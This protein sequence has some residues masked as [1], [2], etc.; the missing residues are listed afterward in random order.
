M[1]IIDECSDN[2]MLV[3]LEA[4]YTVMCNAS[5][6]NEILDNDGKSLLKN[7]DG[8]DFTSFLLGYKE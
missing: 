7:L 1:K 8:D 3:I 5:K 4:G 6:S 2:E